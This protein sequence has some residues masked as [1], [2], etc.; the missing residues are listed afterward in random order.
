MGLGV[1]LLGGGLFLLL[2]QSGVSG[3]NQGEDLV[4]NGLFRSHDVGLLEQRIELLALEGN[5]LDGHGQHTPRFHNQRD[6][7]LVV[8]GLV[9]QHLL[10]QRVSANVHQALNVVA[11][12][13]QLGLDAQGLASVEPLEQLPLLLLG[14]IVEVGDGEHDR[15]EVV[16]Q[17][18]GKLAELAPG[19]VHLNVLVGLLVMHQHRLHVRQGELVIEELGH[20]GEPLFAIHDVVHHAGLLA[21]AI[22][23]PL[24]EDG[25]HRVAENHALNE[26]GL[27]L[28]LPDVAPLD[29]VIEVD[30]ALGNHALDI[31]GA[32]IQ[33]GL[34]QTHNDT[35]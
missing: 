24:G 11:G 10:E 17:A 34:F 9:G 29:D 13:E 12:S 4:E 6:L 25:R 14:E 2:H 18:L 30:V 19:D 7:I 27:A 23:N 28:A 1:Q 16:F 20:G 35:S 3:G 31:L 15:V 8:T 22:V 26:G 33:I 21:R 5:L 32:P